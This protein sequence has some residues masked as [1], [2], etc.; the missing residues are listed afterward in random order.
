MQLSE[1]IQNMTF[2]HCHSFDYFRLKQGAG[3]NQPLP[4]SLAKVVKLVLNQKLPKQCQIS[5]WKRRPLYP[6]QVPNVEPNVFSLC[7]TA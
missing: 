5:D 6:Q 4:Q 7:F 3:V 2:F 1:K